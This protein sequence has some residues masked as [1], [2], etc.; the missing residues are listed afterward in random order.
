MAELGRLDLDGPRTI[1]PAFNLLA[2]PFVILG[3][4][5]GS[6]T[7]DLPGLAD[8]VGTAEAAG[9]M[10][11]L[12][13]P[14]TRLTAELAFL[15]GAAEAAPGILGALR[16]G[17]RPD[18]AGL[19][20]AALANVLA[21]LCA[22][23]QAGL[24]DDAALI[25]SQPGP[26]DA[27]LV[28]AIDLDR[29]QAGMPA[30]VPAMLKAEQDGLAERH[31]AALVQACQARKDAAAR[32]TELVRG[33]PDGPPSLFLRRATAIW[34]RQTGAVM[35]LLEEA[36][37]HAQADAL[38]A[39]T[40]DASERL[41]KA[42]RSWAGVSL[43]QRLSDARAGL[44]HRAT[45]RLQQPWREAGLRLAHEGHPDLALPVARA[46]AECFADLPGEGARLTRDLADCVALVEDLSLEQHL[47][48]LRALVERLGAS[49]STLEAELGR[50]PFGPGAP[51][52]AGELWTAFDAAAAACVTS[53]APWTILRELAGRFGGQTRMSGAAP[54]RALLLGLASRAETA[55]FTALAAR[56]ATE[57]QGL[58]RSAAQWHYLGLSKAAKTSWNP[59]QARRARAALRVALALTDDPAERAALQA[60]ERGMG[61]RVSRNIIGYGAIAF[62]LV[63]AVKSN[64]L[65]HAHPAADLAAAPQTPITAPDPAAGSERN[66]APAPA[67][68]VPIVVMPDPVQPAPQT[69]TN[70]RP[71]RSIPGF[72]QPERSGRDTAR[73]IA[74]LARTRLPERAPGDADHDF[75]L[76]EVRWCM[77]NGI[78]LEAAMEA[79][80]AVHDTA[81]ADA[82][83]A[84]VGVWRPQC[85]A[86]D[87]SDR[88]HAQG[89][90]ETRRDHAL[91]E[92]EG[93]DMLQGTPR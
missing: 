86:Y 29:R 16:R 30:V 52:V 68:L 27:A 26:A 22:H 92:R 21:H 79:A 81:R 84:L 1:I 93:R 11:T 13:V 35:S 69:A 3:A 36:A 77:F 49:P 63:M 10:R 64:F 91:L 82:V 37:A 45:L 90:R 20:G 55:G 40:P 51:G 73:P 58:E 9:A 5:P 74:F 78:R 7:S 57:A 17:E 39:R 60:D 59:F 72:G 62:V 80:D 4:M 48:P 31:A 88:N 47:A 2:S 85:N 75:S 53:E 70:L 42:I 33:A 44:D 54:A 65:D 14:K 41:A 50:A 56:L 83:M 18:T 15:P 71:M 66:P 25:A 24:G 8:V 43:P 61:L 46:L 89:E 28:A 67:P 76:A 6:P 23:G 38:R 34:W 19:P 32:L 12:S 87:A